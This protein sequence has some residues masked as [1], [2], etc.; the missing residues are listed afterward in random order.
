[1]IDEY[2]KE[3]EIKKL[4][5]G[6]GPTNLLDGWLNTDLVAHNEKIL[7]LDVL[8]GPF[9]F[10]DN[11]FDYIFSEHMIEHISYEHALVMLKECFR[12]LKKG[13]R[14]RISAPNLDFLFKVYKEPE[15]KLHKDWLTYQN[16]YYAKWAPFPDP[17]YI[18][19]NYVRAWG[20]KFIYDKTSLSASLMI[21]GFTNITE[22]LIQ[23]SS[24]LNLSNL[25]NPGRLPPGFLQLETVTLEAVKFW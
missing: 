7:S 23:N 18:I 22:H 24:D 16:E 14:I 21:S 8:S 2:F 19:N 6:C 9:P 4:H 3:N 1:M 17:S 13:G 5:I 20:H 10:Q 12:I 25:E 15:I 11:S